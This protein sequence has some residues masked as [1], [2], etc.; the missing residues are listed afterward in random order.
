MA[1]DHVRA[2]LFAHLPP[3]ARDADTLLSAFLAYVAD[4]GLTLYP[5]Q[6]EAILELATGSNVILATPTGSGKSL[7]ALALH[8]FS[9]ARGERSIYTCPIKALASEKF[10]QL[11][12]ELGP[13]NVGLMTGDGAVNRD[14]AVLCCTAEV[15]ANMALREGAMANVD[16]VVVDE[17]HYYADRERGTAWQ[18]PLLVLE[19]ARFL[20]MS[21]T[22]GDTEPFEKALS[23]LTGKPTAVVRSTHRPVP[24]DFSYRE[25][26]LHE[27]VADLLKKGRSPIYLVNFTQRACAEEAQNLMSVDIATKDEKKVIGEALRGVRFDTPYGKELQRF[28]RHGIGLHHAGLLPKYRLAIETLAQ[29]GRSEGLRRRGERRRAGSRACDR[30]PTARS[31]GRL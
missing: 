13:E 21:A 20:L 27:T 28:V 23:K 1:S 25:T 31:E 5:A 2:P 29:T 22:F 3:G 8:F 12:R 14:A 4:T 30:K 26:P 17:F 7:V 10:F 18:V 6:E 24:L 15:L 9:V 11:S 16:H 19:R